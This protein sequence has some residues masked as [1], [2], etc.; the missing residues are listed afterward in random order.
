MSKPQIDS[1]MP[2]TRSDGTKYQLRSP[3]PLGAT[4]NLWS[5]DLEKINFKWNPVIVPDDGEFIPMR[6]DIKV[7]RN[8]V[9]L[10][11][12]MSTSE[13]PL[14]PTVDESD[15]KE[16][17]KEP[18][19]VIVEDPPKESVRPYLTNTVHMHCLPIEITSHS[20]DFY[21]DHFDRSSYG[22]KFMFESVMV[23]MGDLAM[24]FWT[25]IDRVTEGSIVYP[26]R[27]QI[28]K[29]KY[30]P[31]QQYRW[32]KITEVEDKSPGYLI[33]AVASDIQ[34]DFS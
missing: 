12:F 5:S 4:Q 3:N 32:W 27:T 14:P 23:E 11:T 28:G 18:V 26:F 17:P 8:I 29:G 30:K 15:I 33:K 20:D 22:Q 2:I 21:G 9:D 1:H 25:D 19:A 34:P 16:E 10:D 7:K 31:L 13:P 6:S 24:L